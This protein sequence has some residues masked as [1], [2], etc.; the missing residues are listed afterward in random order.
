MI[1]GPFALA[2]FD[3]KIRNFWIFAIRKIQDAKYQH[4]ASLENEKL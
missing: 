1:Y 2:Q 3:E 4:M